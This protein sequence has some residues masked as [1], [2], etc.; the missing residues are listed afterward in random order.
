MDFAQQHVDEGLAKAQPQ[1]YFSSHF[2]LM[3]QL[4][5]FSL[6]SVLV[7]QNE[8][9]LATTLYALKKGR[10]MGMRTIFNPGTNDEP[11]YS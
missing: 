7:T 4:V 2:T 9:P 11:S 6:F 8:V 10:E 5:P 3:Y 1:E